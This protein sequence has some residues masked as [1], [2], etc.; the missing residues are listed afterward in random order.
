L[1]AEQLEFEEAARVRDRI[2]SMEQD[3]EGGHGAV[4]ATLTP[5][6]SSKARRA[7]R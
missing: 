4:V 1:L 6:K 3:A 5:K 7:R 2:R